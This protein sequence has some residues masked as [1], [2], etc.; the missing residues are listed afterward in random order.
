[1]GPGDDGVESSRLIGRRAVLLLG[2]AGTLAACTS[3]SPSLPATVT[4]S[5]DGTPASRA[6]PRWMVTEL[7]PADPGS[8]AT[9]LSAAANAVL[10]SSRIVL[11]PAAVADVRSGQVLDSVLAAML[12]CP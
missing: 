4:S 11:A 8:V 3:G 12:A 9:R 6:S 10:G 7:R 1:M 2:G 5:G